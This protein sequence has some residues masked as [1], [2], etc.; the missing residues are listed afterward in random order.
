MSRSPL[1]WLILGAVAIAAL[2]SWLTLTRGGPSAVSAPASEHYPLAPFHEIEIGGTAEVTVVQGPV[3][4]IDVEAS[5]RT[6]VNARVTSGRLLIHARDRRRWWSRLLG[7][8]ATEGA[9]VVV[10][11]KT[12]DKLALTGNVKVSVPE[13][14]TTTF[15]IGASGG[16][17]LV[18]DDLQATTL[19]VD[20][21][22]ALKA[23]IAGQVDDQRVSISG[24]GT[25]RAERLRSTNATV[26]VSGVGNVLVNVER[27][28]RAS[29]SGAGLIEYVGDPEVVENVSG[30][31]R[32]RRRDTSTA[33][34]M[35]VAQAK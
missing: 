19:R 27:K 5:P 32:V 20:G 28:L 9:S 21:S 6:V 2:L 26:H 13:L 12:L 1:P 11:V 24:A 23:D 4:A 22:G 10:H 8:R 16:A 30:I 34:G 18:V 35:R 31:G 29:I 17:T 33:P 15:R 3:E 7:H 25:Y 14:S